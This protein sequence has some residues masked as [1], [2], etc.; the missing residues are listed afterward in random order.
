[1]PAFDVKMMFVSSG[2][3]TQSESNGPIT[4]RGTGLKGLAGRV[5]IPSSAETTASILPR[6]WVSADNTT[7][8]LA[9]TY[10][11][12]AQSMNVNGSPPALELI[13]PIIT[14]KKY[15]KEELVV[16]GTTATSFG[17]GFASGLVF[18]VGYDHK[19]K[20]LFD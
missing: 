3:I 4:V 10:Q 18:N 19:R 5:C 9:A 17:S 12:G 13:T 1:M 15:I 16:V 8:F 7:Y 6:Y 11:S 20:V 2:A 14:D